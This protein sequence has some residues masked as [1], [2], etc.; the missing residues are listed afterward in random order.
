MVSSISVKRGNRPKVEEIQPPIVMGRQRALRKPE[1]HTA[2]QAQETDDH[3][4]ASVEGF[5]AM[6]ST[7]ARGKRFWKRRSSNCIPAF[8]SAERYSA[9]DNT[10][11]RNPAPPIA[12]ISHSKTMAIADRRPR[13]QS[14]TRKIKIP[15]GA[16]AEQHRFSRAGCS[17]A[18]KYC[19]TSRIKI[20]PAGG[21]S[22]WRVS[23]T[24][25][26]AVRGA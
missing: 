4:A 19:K 11:G 21:N 18:D 3:R 26:Y 23:G 2:H 10:R 6:N 7:C 14:G 1:G 5:L 17:V 22:K 25:T 13:S 9:I 20:K 15:S 8:S 24:V 16:S 12:K